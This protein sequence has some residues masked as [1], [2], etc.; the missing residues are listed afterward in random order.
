M[1]MLMRMHA[2]G[3]LEDDYA[4]GWSH[5]AVNQSCKS[6]K[7]VCRQC[8]C[9]LQVPHAAMCRHEAVAERPHNICRKALRIKMDSDCSAAQPLIKQL[10][11]A[12]VPRRGGMEEQNMLSANILRSDW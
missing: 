12:T 9:I 1:R 6:F 5:A 7:T 10:Q 11:F 4:G 2:A 8:R 3:M